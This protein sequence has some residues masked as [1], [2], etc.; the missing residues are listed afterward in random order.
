[1]S[2]KRPESRRRHLVAPP[3]GAGTGQVER[4]DGELGCLAQPNPDS[5]P[6]ARRRQPCHAPE[7]VVL[8]LPRRRHLSPGQAGLAQLAEEPRRCIVR[9]LAA[10]RIEILHLDV[11]EGRV[12]GVADLVR[13]DEEQP[14]GWAERDPEF[15]PGHGVQEGLYSVLHAAAHKG[16]AGALGGLDHVREPAGL[17]E[18]DVG[19][20]EQRVPG[21][22]LGEPGCVRASLGG[23]LNPD[24]ALRLEPTEHRERPVGGSAVADHDVERSGLEVAHCTDAQLGRPRGVQTRDV[25]GHVIVLHP[26]SSGAGG[27][28]PTRGHGPSGFVGPGAPVGYEV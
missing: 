21:L 12:D 6:R 20:R 27:A 4:D 16:A 23:A 28:V 10:E 13:V 26:A 8:G 3:L 11:L 7:M 17:P 5:D 14:G 24:P 15:G 19:V 9:N 18:L 25:R 1:M 22:A 2:L